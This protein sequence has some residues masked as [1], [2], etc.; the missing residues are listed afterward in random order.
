MSGILKVVEEQLTNAQSF[1]SA[2]EEIPRWVLNNEWPSTWIFRGQKDST[3]GLTPA[4]WRTNTSAVMQQLGQL[5]QKFIVE[6]TPVIQ[7]E[8]ERTQIVQTDLTNIVKSYTQARAE[9]E[10]IYDF[11]KLAD[12]LGH[13]VP[14]MQF[15]Q[16]PSGYNC[17][18]ELRSF[19]L[20]RFLPPPNSATALAQHHGIPT[21]L[22]DWTKNPL[23]AA[24]FAANDVN[25]SDA[26]GSIAVWAIQINLLRSTGANNE[27]NA[28]L[29]YARFLDHTVPNSENRYLHSQRGLFLYPVYGCA[30]YAITGEFPNLEEFALQIESELSTPIIKKL[31][32]PYSEV[33]ELLRLLWL[34]GVSR[35][36]LMPTLDNITQALCSRWQWN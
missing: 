21:R 18:A 4:A 19:P 7:E 13:S 1:I 3:W 36:Q 22:L 5:R 12:E 34:K 27:H 32:L 11:V 15:Y 14:D 28:P 23:Y 6:Y 26:D 30:H 16:F 10:L 24:Y 9:Y 20:L 29:G 2:L 33:G 8:L 17:I 25:P 35:A 31:T